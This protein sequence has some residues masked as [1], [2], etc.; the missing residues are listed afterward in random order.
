MK[1]Y[2]FCVESTGKRKNVRRH[3]RINNTQTLSNSPKFK[4]KKIGSISDESDDITT[5][6]FFILSI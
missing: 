1:K 6:R 4:S 2:G 3:G 5:V